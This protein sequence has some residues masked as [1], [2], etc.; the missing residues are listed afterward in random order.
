MI[1]FA[2]NGI[3]SFSTAPLRFI[4]YVGLIMFIVSMFFGTWVFFTYVQG[5]TIKGW[6]SS[7][8]VNLVFS[9]INMICLGI[10]GEYIG[11]IYQEVKKRPRYIIEEVI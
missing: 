8:L 7:L 3:T 9:G 2:W 5:N 11:K 4:F 6:T 1:A 10:I